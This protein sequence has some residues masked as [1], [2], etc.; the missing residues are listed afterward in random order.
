M[1]LRPLMWVCGQCYMQGVCEMC[2]FLM[3]RCQ[4]TIPEP[5]TGTQVTVILII[6]ST[7]LRQWSLVLMN[8]NASYPAF[9]QKIYTRC[10]Y[11]WA[12]FEGELLSNTYLL[13]Y[14]NYI[15]IQVNQKFFEFKKGEYRDRQH[16][17]KVQETR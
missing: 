16:A 15:I 11:I 4:S 6:S 8:S 2:S 14:E 13:W 12:G 7:M 10:T 9:W 5:Y 3:V 17:Y 1:W